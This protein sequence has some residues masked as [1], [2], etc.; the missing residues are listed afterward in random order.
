MTLSEAQYDNRRAF[1]G[2]GPGACISG[3]VWLAAALVMRQRGVGQAFAVLFFGGILIFPLAQ[4]L[5]RFLFR[6][7]PA[8]AE[9]LL[10]RVALESTIAMVA[11]LFAAWLFLPFK[12]SY[13]FPLAAV[14]VGTHYA[15][16]R[17]VYGDLLFWVLGGLVATVGILD[18]L[19]YVKIPGGPTLA[20]GVIEVVFGIILTAR[21]THQ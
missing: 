4:L 1:V 14:A 15:A 21:K 5:S 13:V 2:G 19:G 11:G 6:R 7:R 9:N 18:I 12:P 16:F 20:V 8:Q 17:T 3:A 10:G